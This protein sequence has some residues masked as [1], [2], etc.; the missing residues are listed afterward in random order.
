MSIESWLPAISTNAI[1]SICLVGAI[2]LS[3]NWITERLG[4]S[5]QHEY[6][7]KLTKFKADLN[8]DLEKLRQE[9]SRNESSFK[10]LR[11]GALSNL[12]QREAILFEKKVEAIEKLW[13]AKQKLD[14]GMFVAQTVGVLNWD[15]IDDNDPPNNDLGIYADVLI[16]SNVNMKDLSTEN[17][18]TCRLYLSPLLWAYFSAYQA[19][20]LDAYAR[21]ALLQ[22][23][24]PLSLL[25]AGGTGELLKKAM[26]EYTKYI[27]DHGISSYSSLLTS[28]TE[29]LLTEI[30][31]ELNSKEGDKIALNKAAEIIAEAEQLNSF[32][33]PDV[34]NDFK[35]SPPPK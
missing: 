2:W 1:T 31:Q 24:Q 3:R 26:P 5:V 30:K 32:K 34:P 21:M 29:K 7:Q 4:R 25:K 14:K 28:L 13:E 33:A 27:D 11:E 17:L 12:A 8:I 20:I 35:T 23:R 9:T 6:N 19:V 15:K 22:N 10:S 18:Q 16:N